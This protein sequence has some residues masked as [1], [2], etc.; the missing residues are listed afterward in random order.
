MKFSVEYHWDKLECCVVGKTYPPEFFKFIKNSTVRNLMERISAETNS[1]LVKLCN[2]LESFG[3]EIFRPELENNLAY[4]RVGDKYLPP[5]LTPRDDMAMIGNTFF[6]PST[7]RTGKWNSIKGTS[8]PASPPVTQCDWAQLDKLVINEL[9]DEYGIKNIP[10]CYYRDYSS[11]KN[12]EKLVSNNG[13]KIVYDTKINSAMVYRLGKKLVFGTWNSNEIHTV[14]QQADCLFPDY[15]NF[16]ID[17]QGHLDG[18]IY[19]VTEGLLL[20]SSW[21]DTESLKLVFPDWQIVSLKDF[22]TQ[23]QH[24]RNY[25]QIKKLNQGK[26]LIPSE[27]NNKETIE[28]IDNYFSNWLGD[29]SESTFDLNILSIDQ[30]NIAVS[31]ENKEIFKIF[32][33]Y[34]VTPHVIEMR[35]SKFWDSGIHC[36]TN[37]LSR[38]R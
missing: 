9:R 18:T 4:Y 15:D 35:H 19:P 3:V 29:V 8:W 38:T 14:K 28:I 11:F 1:D 31:A 25:S 17:S 33:Q 30:N 21:V 6:M 10:D 22:N 34:N 26:W 12:I 5:P 2:C 16:V 7:N 13:N 36:M 24:N 20:T 32:D 27:Y 23:N 37:D